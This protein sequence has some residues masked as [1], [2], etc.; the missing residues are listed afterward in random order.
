MDKIYLDILSEFQIYQLEG[1]DGTFIERDIFLDDAKYERVKKKVAEL[2]QY[3]SSS[4]LTSLQDNAGAKQK[5]PLINI[6]RQLLKAKYYN[7][8]PKRKANGY[9]KSGKKLYK[10]F[11]LIKK[12]R[13][14]GDTS[15]SSNSSHLCDSDK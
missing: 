10:R 3:F 14:S 8:E 15:V 12:M 9:D 7:M 13:V 2:K 4:L 1:L 11:F 5:F 6:V